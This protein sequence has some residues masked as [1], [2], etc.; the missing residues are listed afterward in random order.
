M[1]QSTKR[2]DKPIQDH[3]NGR[4]S[5]RIFSDQNIDDEK[6][7]LIFE[8]A[9]WSPS[10]N[11]IQPWRFI[12]GKKGYENFDK[13]YDLLADFNK[14]WANNAQCL[15]LGIYKKDTADGKENFHGLYDL[16]QSV[17]HLTMQAQSM[18]IAVHQM[19]GFDH[20]KANKD[21]Q[22]PDNYHSAVVFAMGY[23]GGEL[24]N[25]PDDLKEEEKNRSERKSLDEI[26]TELNHFL[27]DN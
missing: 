25:L 21:F 7:S 17:A 11:N 5:P 23:Y 12:I 9:R 18:G 15:V 1:N 26:V 16:G 24:E 2:S 8:A 6:L 19:A 20:Q 22:L 13:I 27:F 10:S 4:Y 3:L 14:Q